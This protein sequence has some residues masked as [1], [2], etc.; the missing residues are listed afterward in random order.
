MALALHP[1]QPI[2]VCAK[3]WADRRRYA[4]MR[5]FLL[6]F[7]HRRWCWVRRTCIYL[8][9]NLEMRVLLR[10][11]GSMY[12]VISVHLFSVVT[13][14]SNGFKPWWV[15]TGQ[16]VSQLNSK[17]F[18]RVS[19]VHSVLIGTCITKYGIYMQPQI[20]FIYFGSTSFQIW[21]LLTKLDV[22]FWSF[23]LYLWTLQPLKWDSLVL[24]N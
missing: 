15:F 2:W 21:A 24:H 11:Q 23:Q 20:L 19:R 7:H 9:E 10:R 17:I 1:T 3:E 14:P 5:A 13:D 6:I 4:V 18:A 12:G 16:S 22:I 8:V